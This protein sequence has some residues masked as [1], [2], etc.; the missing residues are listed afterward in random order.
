MRKLILIVVALVLGTAVGLSSSELWRRAR[1]LPYCK[2]ANNAD[3]YHKRLVRVKARIH[4]RAG[5][6][7]IYEDCDPVEALAASVDLEG[8]PMASGNR[9]VN[10]LLLSGESQGKVA[11][12][13][14]EGEFD[15]YASTGCWAPKFRIAAQKIE[16]TSSI[17]DYVPP[18]SDADGPALRVKH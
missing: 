8:G 15:A 9:Y 13:I 17:S 12:A 3:S 7:Y 14:V 18:A 2:V 5:G 4:F 10:E 11:D 1:T 16:L 6:M